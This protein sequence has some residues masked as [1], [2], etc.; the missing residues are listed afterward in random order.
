MLCCPLVAAA[1]RVRRFQGRGFSGSSHMRAELH[2]SQQKQHKK[3]LVFLLL[4]YL[5]PDFAWQILPRLSRASCEGLCLLRFLF[6]SPLSRGGLHRLCHPIAVLSHLS[7]GAYYIL[8]TFI[9][10]LVPLL[11]CGQGL[12]LI[13]LCLFEEVLS[14][15]RG[16]MEVGRWLGG[17]RGGKE[18]G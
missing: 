13:R 9:F 3:H 18:R 16:M 14:R 7:S 4:E 17:K 6:Y 5:S 1:W 12:S 10:V 11:D 2:T 15:H 8:L